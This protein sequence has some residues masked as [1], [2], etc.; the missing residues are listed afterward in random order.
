MSTIKVCDS[1]GKKFSEN[2]AISIKNAWYTVTI[3][4]NKKLN[5]FSNKKS[6]LICQYCFNKIDYILTRAKR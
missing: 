2:N 1:C 4:D 3:S 6:Y 5:L